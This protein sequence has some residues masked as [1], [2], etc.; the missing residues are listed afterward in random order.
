MRMRPVDASGDVL[1]VLGAGDLVSGAAAVA[2]LAGDRLRLLS[3]DWWE[4]PE[5]GCG[6]LRMLQEGRPTEADARAV[7]AYLAAYVRETPGVTEV[8]DEAWEFSGREFRWSCT[9]VTDSGTASV[10]YASPA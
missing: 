6:V 5:W 9:V 4:N 1:P 2:L 3:G 10:N 8:R 7:S